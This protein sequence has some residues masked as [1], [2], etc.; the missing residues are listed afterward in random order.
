MREVFG[1][2]FEAWVYGEEGN[3]GVLEGKVMYVRE[4]VEELLW[5]AFSEE[6]IR[7][8]KRFG[9]EVPEYPQVLR[10][11]LVD[12]VVYVPDQDVTTVVFSNESFLFGHYMEADFDGEWQCV[13]YEIC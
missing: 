4:H 3:E 10:E 8:L 12:A 13:G 2:G 11:L 9:K 6:E 5:R 1:V 7:V